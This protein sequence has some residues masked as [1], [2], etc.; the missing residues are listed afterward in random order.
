MNA[1]ELLEAGK[2]TAAIEALNGELKAR[3]NDLPGRTI[4]FDLLCYAGDLPAPSG[5]S[6]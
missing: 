3:P 2:L 4:L 6:T 1:R 5:S